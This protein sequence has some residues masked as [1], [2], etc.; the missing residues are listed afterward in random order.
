MRQRL[1]IGTYTRREDHVDGRGEGIYC[2][3][4]ETGSGR[5]EEV[6]VTRGIVNP[7]FVAVYGDRLY[8]VS[9]ITEHDGEVVAYAINEDTGALSEISRQTTLGTAP[10]YVSVLPSSALVAN[11]GGG[12]TTMLPRLKDGALAP[13]SCHVRHAGSSVNPQRQLEPHPHAIVPD[14]EQDFALVPDLGTDTVVAYALRHRLGIM[15]KV[16]AVRLQDGAGPRHVAFRSDGTRCYVVAELDSTV[17]T[18]SYNRGQ[19]QHLQTLCALPADWRG[20]PSG[21]DIH[22]GRSGNHVYVSLR[23]PSCVA[24]LQVVERG[25]SL[26]GHIP[27]RGATPRNFGIAPSGQFLVAANQDSG[28][29]EVFKLDE[30]TGIPA[31]TGWSL[32]IP[33]PACVAFTSGVPAIGGM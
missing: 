9:E 12:S 10:C 1:Y 28:T 23:G 21:A 25:L 31:H 5:M 17:T 7:S 13:P 22:I 30:S 26:E 11:Y 14:C 6:G 3:T 33:S 2:V 24:V 20:T 32:D 19:L 27:T 18:F 16:G 29:L 15:E 4:L 8:A